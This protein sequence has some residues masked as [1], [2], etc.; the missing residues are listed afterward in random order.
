MQN[1]E[2]FMRLAIDQASYAAHIGEIAVGCVIIKNGEVLSFGYNTRESN[3]DPL[4]HA[5]MMAIKSA[6]EATKDWRLC[7]CTLYVTLEPCPMCMGAIINARMDKVVF[8]AFDE[9]GGCCGSLITLADCG[10]AHRPR[11][12]GG[13]LAEQCEGLLRSCFDRLR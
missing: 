7:G 3:H 4:G 9:K 12:E 1:H 11:M 10:F 2:A 8:G 6:S 5:E 13:I